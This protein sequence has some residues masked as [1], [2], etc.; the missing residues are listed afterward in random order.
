MSL[1]NI[2]D[3]IRSV[4]PQEA[5]RIGQYFRQGDSTGA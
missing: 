2:Q 1:E 4:A 3:K 5:D